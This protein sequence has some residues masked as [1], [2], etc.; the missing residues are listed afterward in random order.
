MNSRLRVRPAEAADIKTLAALARDIWE[1]H[2]TPIIGK[3]Q[4][5]YMLEKYQSQSAIKR[6]IKDGCVYYIALYDDVPCGY[7]AVAR[8]ADALY[9]SR[10]Y[11]KQGYRRKGIARAMLDMID[12]YARKNKIKRVWLT[13]NRYDTAAIES[14]KKLGFMITDRVMG[15]GGAGPNDCVLEKKLA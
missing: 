14:Y 12:A 6:D 15:G 11:V 1:Q 8:D 10:M 5:A 9:L 7:S 2:Y 13:C 3:A 4:V